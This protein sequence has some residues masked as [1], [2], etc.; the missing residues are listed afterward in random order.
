MEQSRAI[1]SMGLLIYGAQTIEGGQEGWR[2]GGKEGEKEKFS[3]S[4]RRI[5]S[6]LNSV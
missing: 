5:S 6:P 4:S 2:E 1:A 3:L